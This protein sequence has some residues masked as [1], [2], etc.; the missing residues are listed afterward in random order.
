MSIRCVNPD[1]SLAAEGKLQL[2]SAWTSTLAAGELARFEVT[3][4]TE[5]AFRFLVKGAQRTVIKA[6]QRK[7]AAETAVEVSADYINLL[8]G[9]SDR[10]ARFTFRGITKDASGNEVAA[11]LEFVKFLP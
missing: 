5:G 3:L 4:P 7:V 1:V 2:H 10:L 8:P 9:P 11:E 6:K